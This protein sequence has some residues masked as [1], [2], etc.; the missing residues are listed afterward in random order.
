MSLLD[1]MIEKIGLGYEEYDE[2]ESVE[3][4]EGS[5]TGDMRKNAPTR[6]NE[7]ESIPPEFMQHLQKKQVPTENNLDEVTMSLKQ[8]EVKKVKEKRNSF[9]GEKKDKEN[10]SAVSALAKALHVL[11]V[12][13]KDFDDSQKIAD[14]IRNDRSVIINCERID[15]VVTSRIKDFIC[16]VVYALGGTVQKISETSMFCAPRS[17]DVKT[18]QGFVED[19]SDEE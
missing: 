13:P 17:V 6:V 10:V 12:T 11:I 9:F 5:G 4:Q 8:N 16:G 14:Y 19:N 7:D 1:K 3:E 2:E 18:K 15:E